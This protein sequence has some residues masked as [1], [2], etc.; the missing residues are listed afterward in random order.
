MEKHCLNKI[1]QHHSSWGYAR[2]SSGQSTDVLNWCGG[3]GAECTWEQ[4]L[5]LLLSPPSTR[6]QDFLQ[7]ELKVQVLLL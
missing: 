6:G 1:K 3:T 5:N 4:Q 2:P 7:E